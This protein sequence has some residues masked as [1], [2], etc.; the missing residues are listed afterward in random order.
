M[1]C[2]HASATVDSTFLRAACNAWC[3]STLAMC[4]TCAH[5]WCYI[6]L[7]M[8]L[9]CTQIC[10]PVMHLTCSCRCLTYSAGAPMPHCQMSHLQRW[11]PPGNVHGMG[12]QNPRGAHPHHNAMAGPSTTQITVAWYQ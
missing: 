11:S 1:P 5:E 9:A 12:L 2:T 10:L 7:A 8:C 6:T 4:L 3:S